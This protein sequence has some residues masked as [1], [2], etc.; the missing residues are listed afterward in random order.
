MAPYTPQQNGIV[1]RSFTFLYDK[2][3][4]MLNREGLTKSEREGFWEECVNMA[5]KLDNLLVRK[6][7]CSHGRF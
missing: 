4:S 2:V 1:E 5:V 6:E 3:R 7:K